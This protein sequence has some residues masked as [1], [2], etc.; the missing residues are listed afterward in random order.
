MRGLI[1]EDGDAQIVAPLSV[2]F[3]GRKMCAIQQYLGSHYRGTSYLGTNLGAGLG[4]AHC[5]GI[6][7]R[8][9]F[10]VLPSGGQ[11]TKDGESAV[12]P[13]V[14]ETQLSAKCDTR[15]PLAL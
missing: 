9:G 7:R 10:A 1:P 13:H 8:S 12:D 6:K 14:C 2:D 3:S 5:C 4:I 15:D 11:Q